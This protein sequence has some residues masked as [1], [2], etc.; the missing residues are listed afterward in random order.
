MK[1]QQHGLTIIELMIVV[2]TVS[3]LAAVAIPIY[4][5]Y[6]RRAKVAEAVNLMAGLKMPMVEYYMSWSEWPE[7]S[8][9]GGKEEG[10]Y[11]EKVI[12]GRDGDQLYVEAFMRGPDVDLGGKSIRMIHNL[13]T[14]SWRCTIDGAAD[15]IPFELLPSSCK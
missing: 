13:E 11:V 14:G 5:D 3:V 4:T 9:V 10:L 1:K 15:P 8:K 7:V 12:S 6:Q 2:L